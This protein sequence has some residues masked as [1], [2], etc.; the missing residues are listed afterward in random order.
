MDEDAK[1]MAELQ[2]V[3]EAVVGAQDEPED[4][5]VVEEVLETEM[6][7]DD[8]ESHGLVEVKTTFIKLVKDIDKVTENKGVSHDNEAGKVT[9]E[10]A[11]EHPKDIGAEMA[12]FK[13]VEVEVE[14]K[15]SPLEVEFKQ[16]VDKT[17]NLD[18][19]NNTL[20]HNW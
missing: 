7:N 3:D 17:D 13:E 11:S 14:G 10:K 12:E 6:D 9:V 18:E 16:D 1:D 20:H 2:E 8:K 4:L 15:E 19:H 5:E